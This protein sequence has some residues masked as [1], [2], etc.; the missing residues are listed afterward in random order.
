MCKYARIDLGTRPYCVCED[1]CVWRRISSSECL[2]VASFNGPLWETEVQSFRS[3]VQEEF[4]LGENGMTPTMTVSYEVHERKLPAYP[5]AE[6]GNSVTEEADGWTLGGG[7]YS[8]WSEISAESRR[9]VDAIE[10]DIRTEKRVFKISPL[11]LPPDL[12]EQY[13]AAVASATLKWK[14]G[15]IKELSE[16]SDNPDEIFSRV[17]DED[18]YPRQDIVD[19]S[20]IDELDFPPLVLQWISKK[21]A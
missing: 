9:S 15:V 2:A 8:R 6:W 19:A 3:V 21:F 10:Y 13:E 4:S 17:Y 12:L 16:I 5:W 1:K 18:G 7:S 20:T 14:A 11:R